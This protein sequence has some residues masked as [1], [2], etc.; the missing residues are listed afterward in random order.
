[1]RQATP[2]GFPTEVV[3]VESPSADLLPEGVWTLLGDLRIR[4]AWL[5]A[6]LPEPDHALWVDVS[7]PEKQL[8]TLIPW[9]EHWAAVPLHRDSTVVA[10]GG[11]VLTDM[12]GLA[13]SLYLRGVA[14]QA[15]PTSLL[16]MADA[17]LGGKTGVDLAAGK[18]LVGAFH[19]PK[20]LV[21][22]TG[23]LA[24]L[25]ARHLENGRWELVKT[26]LVLGE[27]GWAEDM[28][29]PGPVKVPWIERA[30]AFKAGVVHRDPREAGERRLLNLGH[31]LGHALEAAS[32]YRL[33]H[34]EAVGLGLLGAC[35][36]AGTEGLKPFPPAFLGQLARRLA[37]LAPLVPAWSACLP[38]LARDKKAIHGP[39]GPQIHCILP[40]PGE[41]AVQRLLPPSIWEPVHGR[42][43]ELLASEATRA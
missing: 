31:T 1:M 39:G 4:R 30:L 32:D 43:L 15:W 20:R 42:L 7:E 35:L 24:T 10:V 19:A 17:A 11:G 41:T 8:R 12:A 9:L 21:A 28:L 33:L 36:L 18:N 38:C 37:P 5:E 14:W 29:Q 34:G 27:M 26:A 40:R 22:C 2:T 23:F 3:L 6:G 16:A 25:P 13:A